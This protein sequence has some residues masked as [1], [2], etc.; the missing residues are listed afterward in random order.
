MHN[1]QQQLKCYK[2]NFSRQA[3]VNAKRSITASIDGV[4]ARCCCWRRS[5]SSRLESRPLLNESPWVYVLV[6]KTH[7]PSSSYTCMRSRKSSFAV[8]HLITIS[9]VLVDHKLI[10]RISITNSVPSPDDGFIRRDFCTV[11]LIFL[12]ELLGPT[13]TL[14]VGLCICNMLQQRW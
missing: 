9:L 14:C 7:W 12:M 8:I 6:S 3:D 2:R 13:P 11:Q 5:A 4:S 1:T 10:P